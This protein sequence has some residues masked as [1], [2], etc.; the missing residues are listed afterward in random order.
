MAK[1]TPIEEPETKLRQ[2]PMNPTQA[3]DAL[4]LGKQVRYQ[5]SDGLINVRRKSKGIF[6]FSIVGEKDSTVDVNVKATMQSLH[7]PEY[8]RGLY[9]EERY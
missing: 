9:R 6:E 7:N 2:I 4:I 5:S 1:K 8:R 3:M